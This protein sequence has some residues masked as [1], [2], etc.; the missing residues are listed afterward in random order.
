MLY[1][2]SIQENNMEVNNFILS[3]LVHNDKKKK[4]NTVI[5]VQKELRPHGLHRW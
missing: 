1:I 3:I 2:A 5:V 4:K